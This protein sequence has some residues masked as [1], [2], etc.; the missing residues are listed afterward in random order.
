MNKDI[1]FVLFMSVG[2]LLIGWIIYVGSMQYIDSYRICAENHG[3]Y[4]PKTGLCV[5]GAVSVDQL[6]GG[7]K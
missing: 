4:V 6:K 1:G 2:L 5:F 3:T 7:D